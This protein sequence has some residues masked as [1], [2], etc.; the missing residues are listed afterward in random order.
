MSCFIR[1]YLV[2]LGVPWHLFAASVLVGLLPYNFVS[3]RAGTVLMQLND[4]KDAMDASTLLQ[5]AGIAVLALLPVV[6]KRRQAASHS[7]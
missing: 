5:L 2:Q 7:E 4:T 1:F 6:I 3:V